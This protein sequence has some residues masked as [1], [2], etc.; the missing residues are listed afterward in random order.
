MC[1]DSRVK[2]VLAVIEETV[3][4]LFARSHGADVVPLHFQD[5][6]GEVV[7][8]LFDNKEKIAGS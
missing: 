3:H 4:S 1:E 8:G 7:H 6:V 2:V 5:A